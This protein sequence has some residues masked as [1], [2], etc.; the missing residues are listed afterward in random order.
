[1]TSGGPM[2]IFESIYV[3]DHPIAYTSVGESK[4]RGRSEQTEQDKETSYE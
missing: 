2:I 1:M 4:T 3:Y